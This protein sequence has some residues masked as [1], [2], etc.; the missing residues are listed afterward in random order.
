MMFGDPG[1]F[2]IEFEFYEVDFDIWMEG[3]CCYWISGQRIGDFGLSDSL[4]DVLFLW[5][6]MSYDRDRT[7]IELSSLG[8]QEL[9]TAL[10]SGLY[11]TGFPTQEADELRG[12][13]GQWL[14]HNIRPGASAFRNWIIFLVDDGQTA[15]CLY[16]RFAEPLSTAREQQLKLHEFDQILDDCI[17]CLLAEY[18]RLG[19]T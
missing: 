8:T 5:E 9:V 18:Q 12:I 4:R 17:A 7:N 11:N 6:R 3:R 15:R 14:R 13:E 10:Y 19:G 16:A 1:R 2:A